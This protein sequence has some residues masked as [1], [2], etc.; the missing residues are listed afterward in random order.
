MESGQ[1]QEQV[2]L[3]ANS[4]AGMSFLAQICFSD[5]ATSASRGR[6]CVRRR[7]GQSSGVDIDPRRHIGLGK[8]PLSPPCHEPTIWRPDT[9]N[10]VW[11]TSGKKVLI[12]ML[13]GNGL[14]LAL[15]LPLAS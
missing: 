15:G 9:G 10:R 11:R 8:R 13:G 14:E 12:A 7:G 4:Q 5:S 3:D 1:S 2:G 6:A